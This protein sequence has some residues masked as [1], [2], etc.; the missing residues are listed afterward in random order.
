MIDQEVNSR[1]AA[2]KGNPQALQQK[3][4][5]SQQLID[6]L[7]LQKIKSMQES[8]AREMQMQLAQQQAA[9]G[10]SNST[11]AQQRPIRRT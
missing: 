9:N 7:A 4:A 1:V 2:Y 5:V 10:E 3:Y 11:V 6:L 8:A